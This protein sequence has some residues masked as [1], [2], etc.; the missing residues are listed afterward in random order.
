MSLTQGT[1][2]V[3]CL[4]VIPWHCHY[5][6]VWISPPAAC[7]SAPVPCRSCFQEPEQAQQLGQSPEAQQLLASWVPHLAS[8]QIHA[9]DCQQRAAGTSPAA[10]VNRSVADAATVP[11][12]G[13]TEQ[14][15]ACDSSSKS[16]SATNSP[17]SSMSSY[18]GASVSTSTFSSTVVGSPAGYCP[19]NWVLSRSSSCCDCDSQHSMGGVAAVSCSHSKAVAEEQ[20]RE[21]LAALVASARLHV[22]K[23]QLLVSHLARRTGLLYRLCEEV[24]T[25]CGGAASCCTD[26]KPG[27]HHEA[28]ARQ[29]RLQQVSGSGWAMF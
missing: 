8:L 7:C 16:S 10:G 3:G 28:K 18:G 4:L 19:A 27:A 5:V 23:Q 15:C 13:P 14:A 29:E 22:G 1:K 2:Y 24:L 6:S 25:A 26:E 11:A 20:Q 17:R 12:H 21:A 9:L